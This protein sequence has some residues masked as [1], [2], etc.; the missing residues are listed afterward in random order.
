MLPSPPLAPAL[1]S[2][3]GPPAFAF[4]ARAHPI[5]PSI[6]RPL[7]FR[8]VARLFHPAAT[9]AHGAVPRGEHRA[10]NLPD[11]L[12]EPPRPVWPF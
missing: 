6:I 8:L 1:R 7:L 5:W 9:T 12:P 10:L 3:P 4:P 2:R 11:P